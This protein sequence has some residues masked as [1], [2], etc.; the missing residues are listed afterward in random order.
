MQ[1]TGRQSEVLHTE[2]PMFRHDLKLTGRSRGKGKIKVPSVIGRA[3]YASGGTVRIWIE[4]INADGEEEY[5]FSE[6]G[7]IKV[8]D[9]KGRILWMSDI[10]NP[11]ITGFHDLEG[12]GREKCIA[13]VTNLRTL[14]VFSGLSGEVYWQHTFKEKTVILSHNNMK[15]GRIVPSL[16]GRQ[17][18]VWSEGDNYGYLF[19][20]DKGVRNGYALWKT[21]GIGIGDRTRYRPNVLVGDLMGDGQNS[22]IVIQHSFI[23]VIDSATGH[24]KYA[25]EGPNMRNYGYAGL[26][27]ADNDGK[28][29][30][31]LVND[32]VQLHLSVIKPAG[33]NLEYVWDRYIGYGEHVMKTPPLPVCDIDGDGNPE[34][35]YSVG[36]VAAN[37]WKVEILDCRTGRL[38]TEI[39]NARLLDCGDIDGDGAFEMLLERTADSKIEICRITENRPVTLFST[40]RRIL[41]FT[42]GYRP[43]HLSHI[44]IDRAVEYLWDADGD[45][46]LELSVFEDNGIAAYGWKGTDQL[47]KKETLTIDDNLQIME[48]VTGINK[49]GAGLLCQSKGS[50]SKDAEEF[51]L[52][53]FSGRQMAC[54][55]DCMP[56]VQT[57][58]P[59]VTDIDKDGINEIILGGSV[60]RADIRM[61]DSELSV[62]REWSIE[63]SGEKENVFFDSAAGPG[64]LGAWDFDGDGFKELLFGNTNAELLL[65]DHKGKIIWRKMLKGDFK[66]G[67]VI[68]CTHG[69]FVTEDKYDIYVNAASTAVYIN[70]SMVLDSATGEVVWRRSDGHDSGMGPVDG[71]ASVLPL[72]DDG[73]DDLL[74]LSGDVTAGVD[75]R[76]GRNLADMEMLSDILG[77]RWVGSGHFALADV[78]GDGKEEIYLSGIWGLNGGVLK[79]DGEKWI[80]VWFDYYGN[81]TPIGTPPRYSHQGLAFIDGRVLAAG[82]RNDYKYGCVDA[83]TGELLWTYDIG[84][85]IA[86]ETCTG[87]IDG[88]GYDEFVFG[89]NDGY[90]YSLKHDGT[91]HFRIF[92]GSPPGSPI[93]ADID[94]DGFLEILVTTMEGNLLIIA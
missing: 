47:V 2:W 92:T 91:L 7:R 74:F 86:G 87:D 44:A 25:V 78:D 16:A 59:I 90:V 36:D 22:I 61:T 46:S 89:C 50:G 80:P 60:Y 20:F 4:D 23:W 66:G 8:R 52:Y 68:S 63:G 64:F 49:A 1:D 41:P 72:E 35:A 11:V 55:K 17:I 79:R 33:D 10:C 14:T 40:S 43:L 53:S 67:K 84:D 29:E 75:G 34:I 82:P 71:Y 28:P 24:K 93:L 26:F 18:T 51:L 57:Q 27:D 31:V 45:G 70:E 48:S 37:E 38:K 58:I 85:C 3:R 13:A 32:A 9:S 88:D 83:K 69:R 54:F 39:Q 42:G 6:G 62:R 65:T 94:G 81:E 5:V 76:T 15:I 56:D 19:A 73:L 77:T 12:T 30:L 21:E